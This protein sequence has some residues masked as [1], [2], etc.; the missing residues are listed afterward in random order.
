MFFG[1]ESEVKMVVK[2][3]PLKKCA[4]MQNFDKLKP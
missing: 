3:Y 1:E 4:E 2:W